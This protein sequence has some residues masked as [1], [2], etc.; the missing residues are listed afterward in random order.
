MNKWLTDSVEEVDCSRQLSWHA[1]EES[2]FRPPRSISKA[3]ISDL[4]HE[5]FFFL[6]E[7]CPVCQCPLK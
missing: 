4:N 5:D 7:N 1:V 6:P 2:A 3:K